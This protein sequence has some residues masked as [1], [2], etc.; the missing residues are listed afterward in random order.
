MPHTVLAVEDA[1]HNHRNRPMS[2]RRLG[3]LGGVAMRGGNVGKQV[4][5]V[6]FA[7]DLELGQGNDERCANAAGSYAMAIIEAGMSWAETLLDN[8]L[9]NMDQGTDRPA[10]R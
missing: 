5:R 10:A 7:D 2:L 8:S 4:P 9:A 6:L 3:C 1:L